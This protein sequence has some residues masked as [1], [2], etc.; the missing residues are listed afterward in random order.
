[1][2][3]DSGRNRQESVKILA[4]TAEILTNL[5]TY[6]S[7]RSLAE[8]GG[9]RVCE[10]NPPHSAGSGGVSR[11]VHEIIA[12]IFLSRN[13]AFLLAARRPPHSTIHWWGRLLFCVLFFDRFLEGIL[14]IF[15]YFCPPL[16]TPKSSKITKSRCREVSFFRPYA[17][18][19]LLIDFDKFWVL[20]GV[21]KSDL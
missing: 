7:A 14:C 8:C 16:G 9:L 2:R 5:F 1:M 4:E 12:K 10:L 20:S 6:T 18:R 13:V 21:K 3:Q 11:L 17:F 15:A 19:A